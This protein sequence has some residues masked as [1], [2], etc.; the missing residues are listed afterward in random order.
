MSSAIK[1]S[2]K[3]KTSKKVTGCTPI[4]ISVAFLTPDDENEIH[5]GLTKGCNPDDSV[6]WIIDFLQ[7]GDA[8]LGRG[9]GAGGNL[10]LCQ[11]IRKIQ[12][13]HFP[14]LGGETWAGLAYLHLGCRGPDHLSVVVAGYS[15]PDER[16]TPRQ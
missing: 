2:S 6:F 15:D 8:G 12:F 9:A 4:S 16:G 1:A 5:F 13:D 11:P 10:P 7:P 14:P 3:K